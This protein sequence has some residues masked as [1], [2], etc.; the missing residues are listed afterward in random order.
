MREAP[1]GC[2]PLQI[3]T[4][5]RVQDTGRGHCWLAAFCAAENQPCGLL[6]TPP[7]LF[8]SPPSLALVDT[9]S[10]VPRPKNVL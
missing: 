2:P 6:S 10:S 1:T 8:Y 4:E 9:L 3:E 5:R 7:T